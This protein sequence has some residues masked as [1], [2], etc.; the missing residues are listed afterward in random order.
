MACG[1]VAAS[2]EEVSAIGVLT[3]LLAVPLSGSSLTLGHLG[4]IL[5]RTYA[6]EESR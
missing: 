1:D 2:F 3:N 4:S 5:G 6:V